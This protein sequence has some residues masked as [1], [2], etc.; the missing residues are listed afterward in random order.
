MVWSGYALFAT[1]L[2]HFFGYFAAKRKKPEE[3][4]Y[5]L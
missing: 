4:R 1:Y 5:V 3:R 2:T